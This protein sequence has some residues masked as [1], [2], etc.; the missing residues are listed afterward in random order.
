MIVSVYCLTSSSVS[1]NKNTIKEISIGQENF[2]EISDDDKDRKSRTTIECLA[3]KSRQD[4]SEDTT[5][6]G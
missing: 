6:Q 5:A 4:R 3:L 2:G 1:K